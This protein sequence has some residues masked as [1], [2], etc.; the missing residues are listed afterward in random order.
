V[1]SA[2]PPPRRPFATGAGTGSMCR[3]YRS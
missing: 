1:R 3:W 2:A